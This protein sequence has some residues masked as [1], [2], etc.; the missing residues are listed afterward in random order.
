MP[1]SVTWGVQDTLKSSCEKSQELLSPEAAR[2]LVL[3]SLATF[4]GCSLHTH[5]C[6][7]QQST[8]DHTIIA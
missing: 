8:I 2:V 3:A 4:S 1:P 5:T 7:V 6:V